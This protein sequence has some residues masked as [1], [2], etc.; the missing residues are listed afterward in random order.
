MLG[1]NWK[2]VKN[3]LPFIENIF[4]CFSQFA[5][6]SFHSAITG[7]QQ[8]LGIPCLQLPYEAGAKNSLNFPDIFPELLATF[9]KLCF[10]IPLNDDFWNCKTFYRYNS[11]ARYLRIP[12]LN[13]LYL[14]CTNFQ[15]FLNFEFGCFANANFYKL[16][17]QEFFRNTTFCGCKILSFF[18]DTKFIWN[19]LKQHRYVVVAPLI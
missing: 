8:S 12:C 13:V 15:N 6:R 7:D 4:L 5:E 3:D 2:H 1:K 19:K 11:C 16:L 14:A 10:R 9:K 17:N 18:S